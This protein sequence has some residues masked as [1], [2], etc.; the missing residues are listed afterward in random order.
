MNEEFKLIYQ[1]INDQYESMKKEVKTVYAKQCEELKKNIQF[2][3]RLKESLSGLEKMYVL[4]G[5]DL[6]SHVSFYV[7][8]SQIE[9]A[10]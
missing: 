5:S 7:Y 4:D 8:S 9:K 3:Q 6:E 1:N 10:I 2:I